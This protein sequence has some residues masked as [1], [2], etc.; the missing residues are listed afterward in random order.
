MRDLVRAERRLHTP[1]LRG[2]LHAGEDVPAVGVEA[3]HLLTPGEEGSHLAVA[4]VAVGR[5]GAAR[6]EVAE[7]GVGVLDGVVLDRVGEREF[8]AGAAEG[9]ERLVVALDGARALALDRERGEVGRDRIVDLG[10]R[11][12]LSPGLSPAGRT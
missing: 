7:E 4:A 11:P 12:S 10:H 9:A 1:L 6:L 3:S 2:E 5:G 8:A